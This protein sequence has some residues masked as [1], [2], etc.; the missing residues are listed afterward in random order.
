MEMPINFLSRREQ[1]TPLVV[2]LFGLRHDAARFEIERSS[3]VEAAITAQAPVF[4][5]VSG[6]RDSQ[7]LAYRV[8]EYLDEAGHGGARLLI[9]ADLGQS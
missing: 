9:H 3:E 4:I 7:A 8:C 2:D 1:A 6:G 5:G